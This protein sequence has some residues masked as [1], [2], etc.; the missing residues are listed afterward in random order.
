MHRS[1][2]DANPHLHP[3][4]PPERTRRRPLSI[5]SRP[6]P[7]D[8]IAGETLP[9]DGNGDHGDGN[10]GGGG[11]GG[12]EHAYLAPTKRGVRVF[13][14]LPFPTSTSIPSV[15]VEHSAAA[16]ARQRFRGESYVGSLSPPRGGAEVAEAGVAEEAARRGAGAEAGGGAGAVTG[17]VGGAVKGADVVAGLGLEAVERARVAVAA[18]GVTVHSSADDPIDP[19][20]P[21][22]PLGRLAEEVG[23]SCWSDGGVDKPWD[24]DGREAEMGAGDGG[25]GGAGGSARGA[26]L[27][28]VGDGVGSDGAVSD[29]NGAV[30]GPVDGEDGVSAPSPADERAPRIG[31]ERAHKMWVTMRGGATVLGKSGS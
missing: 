30:G 26:P 2:A 16:A 3:H 7:Q 13:P 6:P 5:G 18:A 15:G 19:L 20:S 27:G 17:G 29:G 14:Q 8:A 31:E 24:L 10:S 11:S 12:G 4:P 9:C 22:D 28:N 25:R 23:E 21:I 1:S